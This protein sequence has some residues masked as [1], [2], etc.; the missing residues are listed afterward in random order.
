MMPQ[1][2]D[3]VSVSNITKAIE[4]GQIFKIQKYKESHP[5]N[6]LILID[7]C[8]TDATPYGNNIIGY[9]Q[10]DTISVFSSIISNLRQVFHLFI[11]LQNKNT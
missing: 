3:V 2:V 5:L 7:I 9:I 10:K 1:N 11:I 8:L 4:A 6:D